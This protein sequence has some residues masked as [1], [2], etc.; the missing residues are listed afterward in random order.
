VKVVTAAVL[1][2]AGKCLI[3][4]RPNNDSLAGLWELPGGKIELGESPETCLKREIMEELCIEV[5]VGQFFGGSIYHYDRGTINLQAYITTWVTGELKLLFHDELAWVDN[6]TIDDYIYAPAD[7]PI[8]EK[9]R[10]HLCMTMDI[11]KP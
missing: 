7:I 6:T 1:I 4:K 10:L 2:K 3:A 5:D 11:L 9:V 8:I